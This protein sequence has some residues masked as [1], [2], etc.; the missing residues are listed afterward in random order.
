MI[1]SSVLFFAWFGLKR[2]GK[3]LAAS[4]RELDGSLWQSGG[5]EVTISSNP[6][7]VLVT[8]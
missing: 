5:E 1:F 6:E 4:C 3:V 2:A 8:H 7:G